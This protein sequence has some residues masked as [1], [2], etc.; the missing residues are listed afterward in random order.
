MAIS[1]KELEQEK[2][3]LLTVKTVVKKL[4]DEITKYVDYKKKNLNDLKKFMWD[5]IHD[6]TDGERA[7]TMYEMDK[8]VNLTNHRIDSIRK[9]KQTI[10]SP[11]FA[12]LLFKETLDDEEIP[13]YIGITTVQDN[14]QFYV[15]DWRAPISSMFYN[16]EIGKAQYESPNRKVEGEIISK[17]QFK[18]VNG[19]I[20]R[21]FRSDINIDDEYLQE[22]LATASSDKMT[23]IVSTI[24]RE[25]N[26]IIRNDK[27]KYLIV[28]GIAGS[29]KTSVALHRI[30]YLLYRDK[31][32]NS[33][34]ILIFSPNN[35]FSDYIS[36]VLPELGE[37][38]V[39]KSTFSEFASS[40]LK[41]C[42]NIENYAQFLE[43][44]YNKGQDK[45]IIDYKMSDQ[46]KN[47]IDLFL[48]DYEN[49]IV[50][51][52]GLAYSNIILSRSEILDMLNIKY[53]KFPMK[54]RLELISESICDTLRIP[55]KTGTKVV[56][57]SL[58]DNSNI[59]LD[60]IKLYKKFL[61]SDFCRVKNINAFSPK[62]ISYEDITGLLYINFKIND[63]P[64]YTN[65]KQIVID[66]VQDYTKFQIELLRNIFKSASFTVLGDINQSINPNYSYDKLAV[67][68]ELF[69]DSRY[70]ELNKSYRSS[71][72]IINY[73]NK[74][75]GINH[76]CSVRKSNNI[77]LEIKS[78][79]LNNIADIL[80]NDIIE[81]QQNNNIKKIAIITKNIKQSKKL[82]SNIDSIKDIFNIELIC[83][84][85]D[86]VHS[87]IIVIPA[88]L[89]K[90]LEF[91][92]VIM[93][94]NPLDS[95][96]ETENRLY[97]VVCTR[98]QHQLKI[99]N[100]PLEIF[101]NK[102]D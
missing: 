32:L 53:K 91:D 25:Q 33:N 37:D 17:M 58:L 84:A 78:V 55:R 65:I 42:K 100:E 10:N 6:Y 68:T 80:K 26:E 73:S 72:E 77:P 87:K 38:N 66:E 52:N 97:Y 95:Y 96:T 2:K 23:N 43:R 99:Y 74:I 21:C 94:N 102:V 44:A 19:E 83:S 45:E 20:V 8:S 3:Y 71:E 46:F 31:S 12:K 27:D 56:F 61:N 90:G 69:K 88:Y 98:A 49:N 13:I 9:Y 4:I 93:Y 1:K 67:L 48:N 39:M 62:K 92:G 18:I 101:K 30:A 15:F 34:D 82:Y 89:A 36:D 7:M 81:M 76:L 59:E 5:Q 70:I 28:Q 22:I 54:E 63:Y 47:D 16:Y 14:S 60:Y 29:G 35:V 64:S 75:L 51:G 86:R 40:F 50:L 41:S 85:D 24:Q 57:N 11:Y 79:D